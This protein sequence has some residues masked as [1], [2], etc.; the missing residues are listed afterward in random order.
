MNARVFMLV[1]VT[2]AFMAIWDADRPADNAAVLDS[3]SAAANCAAEIP[4]LK[5]L[6][7]GTW[8]AISRD[9]DTFRIT[10]ERNNSLTGSTSTDPL[11]SEDPEKQL[12]V[13]K[14]PDGTRWALSK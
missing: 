4:L 10:I 11:V 3:A 1:L 7:P 9:G 12:G 5:S 8:Q 14:A 2:A 13:I 6:Q